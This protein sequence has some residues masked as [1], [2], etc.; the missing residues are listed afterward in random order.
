MPVCRSEPGAAVA[1]TVVSR[2]VAGAGW[3]HRQALVLQPGCLPALS[4]S[5]AGPEGG[6]E[7]GAGAGR[8]PR[9]APPRARAVRLRWR[10]RCA[11]WRP[12]PRRHPRARRLQPRPA[13][14]VRAGSALGGLRAGLTALPGENSG[15]GALQL[16]GLQ[17]CT[18]GLRF[19]KCSCLTP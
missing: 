5:L 7:R 13:A 3:P 15:R 9:P 12:V 2:T 14:Q 4:A 16:L 11:P 17:E 19:P 1:M 10:P 18:G 8:R 6:A